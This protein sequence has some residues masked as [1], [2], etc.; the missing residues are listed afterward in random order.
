MRLTLGRLG[1]VLR[2]LVSWPPAYLNR[3]LYI[4][5]TS[6]IGENIRHTGC[7]EERNTEIR[8]RR[9]NHV[10][11]LRLL[12]APAYETNR[13]AISASIGFLRSVVFVRHTYAMADAV[14]GKR[15]WL[16]FLHGS[17]H[18]GLPFQHP[19]VIWAS[20]VSA[21]GYSFGHA[22]LVCSSG[23]IFHVA[24]SDPVLCD[25]IFYRSCE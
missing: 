17:S 10:V 8:N 7:Q 11:Q 1:W 23:T 18:F 20:A 4:F 2:L 25:S 6:L 19:G 5:S 12:S 21:P 24:G 3:C 22:R 13:P 16:V 9:R 15:L 14:H